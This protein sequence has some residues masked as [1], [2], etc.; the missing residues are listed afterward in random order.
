MEVKSFLGGTFTLYLPMYY[1]ILPSDTFT[2]YPGCKKRFIEDCIGKFNN[3]VNFRGEPH[4]PGNDQM[5]KVGG[6]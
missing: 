5:M 1:A 2:V 6:L 3:V 4:V